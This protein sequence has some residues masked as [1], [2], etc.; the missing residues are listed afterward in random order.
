MGRNPCVAQFYRKTGTL[1][2]VQPLLGH[3]GMNSTVRYLGVELQD[4]LLI[5][6]AVEI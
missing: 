2:A 4:S 3:T 6:E 1:R 5:A